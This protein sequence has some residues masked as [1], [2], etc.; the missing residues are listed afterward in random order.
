[1]NRSA[2][3]TV[4][5]DTRRSTVPQ[6]ARATNYDS[7]NISLSV[8]VGTDDADRRAQLYQ[9][10]LLLRKHLGLKSPSVS[11]SGV[12][13]FCKRTGF[14]VARKL[15]MTPMPDGPVQTLF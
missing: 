1:M 5:M 15:D 14:Q 10:N 12:R 13:S 2:N 4:G 11:E 9:A 8:M 7:I 3:P 6:L